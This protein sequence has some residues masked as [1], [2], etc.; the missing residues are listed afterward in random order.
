MQTALAQ[1]PRGDRKATRC[2]S[3]R[4]I[5]KVFPLTSSAFMV[6]R[7]RSTIRPS[8]CFVTSSSWSLICRQQA[9]LHPRSSR[10]PSVVSGPLFSASLRPRPPRSRIPV[11]RSAK[12]CTASISSP[13]SINDGDEDEDDEN[14]I[15]RISHQLSPAL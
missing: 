4:I 6:Y 14:G 5:S 2:A 12:P 13:T 3:N 11:R 9:V 8:R 15:D 10:T 7:V 1:R